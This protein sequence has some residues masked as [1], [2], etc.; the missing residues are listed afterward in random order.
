MPLFEINSKMSEILGPVEGHI[1]VLLRHNRDLSMVAAIEMNCNNVQAIEGLSAIVYH[2]R[3][4]SP[5]IPLSVIMATVC[6][7]VMA[8]EE[9]LANIDL[10]VS[11]QLI[12]GGDVDG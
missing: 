6:E 10:K 1:G 8:L 5:E 9:G 4:K 3:C 7:K 2:M 11:D 12:Q